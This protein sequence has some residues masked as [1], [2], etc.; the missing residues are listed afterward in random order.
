MN[1]SNVSSHSKTSTFKKVN[2]LLY[3]CHPRFSKICKNNAYL[4]QFLVALYDCDPNLK[5][6]LALTSV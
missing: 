6:F 4:N 1:S 5:H 3:K 2:R